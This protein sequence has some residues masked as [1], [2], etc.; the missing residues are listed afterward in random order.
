[1][2]K[3][4]DKLGRY[5]NKLKVAN[6]AGPLP[7]LP[8]DYGTNPEYVPGNPYNEAEPFK[9]HDDVAFQHQKFVN[10]C[11][12]ACMLML[13]DYRGHPHTINMNVNPRGPVEGIDGVDALVAN[14][15]LLTIGHFPG[16]ITNK[17]IARVLIDHGP[18]IC[19]GSYARVIG[20]IR[21]GHFILVTGVWGDE[22]FFHD[23]WHGANRR[24]PIDWF[25]PKYAGTAYAY[26]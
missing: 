26:A 25:V 2:P 13:L 17:K 12:E 11:G 1:M 22:V 20:P 14:N 4:G 6:T 21:F 18:F 24:K 10:M 3:L 15:H 5:F 7:G 8:A 9:R 16:E 19:S 23:P